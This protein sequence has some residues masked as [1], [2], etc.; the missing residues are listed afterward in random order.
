MAIFCFFSAHTRTSHDAH[1]RTLNDWSL[2]SQNVYNHTRS[3]D[4]VHPD[5]HKDFQQITAHQMNLC[6]KYASTC[7]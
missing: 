1:F 6:P 2:T 5:V 7:V 4:V 3:V